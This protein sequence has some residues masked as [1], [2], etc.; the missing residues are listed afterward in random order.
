[1]SLFEL[2]ERSEQDDPCDCDWACH[3]W[4]R[5]SPESDLDRVRKV[6]KS[7]GGSEIGS[8]WE[9]GEEAVVGVMLLAFE[10]RE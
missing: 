7:S 2:S 1:V 6:P 9:P 5:K 8:L 10:G 4:E 3:E